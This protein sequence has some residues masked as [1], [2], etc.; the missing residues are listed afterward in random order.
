MVSFGQ[1]P[2]VMCNTLFRPYLFRSVYPTQF[3]VQPAFLLPAERKW[4]HK[5]QNHQI[6]K[7]ARFAH[8]FTS[9][10]LIPHHYYILSPEPWTEI[11]VSLYR[12]SSS[13]LSPFIMKVHTIFLAVFITTGF[14]QTCV[15]IDPSGAQNVGNGRGVQF[16]GGQ[17]VRNADC[18]S[19]CCARL[20]GK[21]IC[22]A[23]ATANAACKS[24]C[25]FT[26]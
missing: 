6:Y 15:T 14:A 26:G 20:S 10:Q 18:S 21:G 16:N 8:D 25:G 12:F 7:V 22:S 19:G 13:I 5:T 24:G 1:W 17:C 11:I 2:C 3:C 23:P 9:H 4:L